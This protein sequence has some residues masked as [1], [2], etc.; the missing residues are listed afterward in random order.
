MTI[1]ENQKLQI[2]VKKKKRLIFWN[3][4]FDLNDIGVIRHHR[5][6]VDGFS[7]YW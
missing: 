5:I 1:L 7:E 2:T 3:Q 6:F 4:A